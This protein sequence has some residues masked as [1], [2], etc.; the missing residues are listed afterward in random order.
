MSSNGE[1]AMRS[2]IAV[3]SLRSVCL[4]V[5]ASCFFDPNPVISQPGVNGDDHPAR[6]GGDGDLGGLSGIDE[7]EISG[8]HRG[9][10][11]RSTG[12]GI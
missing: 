10:M 4:L 8:L 2:M 5:G 6:N 3:P 7:R 1:S 11:R 12:A 9:L